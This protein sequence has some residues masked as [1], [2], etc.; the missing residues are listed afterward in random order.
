[1]QVP[2]P[3]EEEEAAGSNQRHIK[4]KTG[5]QF[6]CQE[7]RR[8]SA[9]TTRRDCIDSQL[10]AHAAQLMYTE[11]NALCISSTHGIS[12]YHETVSRDGA[13]SIC[14]MQHFSLK[15]HR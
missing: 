3:Q 2:V 15:S 7:G 12:E 14:I 4:S 10:N 5:A 8:R 1:M 9:A 6:I 13:E 11:Q